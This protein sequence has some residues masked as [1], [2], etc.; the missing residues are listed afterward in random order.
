VEQVL[1]SKGSAEGP[2]LEAASGLIGAD[3]RLLFELVLG[4][5]RWLRRLDWVLGKAAGRPFEKIEAPIRAPLRI[6]AYQLLFLDRVPSYA[7]VNE[8]V[9]DVRRRER[10][11][12]TG[13]ANAVLRRIGERRSL[14]QW[15]VE[16]RSPVERLGVE[17]SHPDFLIERWLDR[18][19]E[20]AVVDLLAA[21][22]RPKPMHLLCFG[23]RQA[24]AAEL[25][26]LGVETDGAALSP[27]GLRV[28]SGDP[29]ATHLFRQGRVY[30]QDDASQAA[31]LVPPPAPGEAILDA[32]ASPGGKG[33]SL[34]AAESTVT[35]VAADV[36]MR[37]LQKLREN[38]KRL[39]LGS[40]L[41][42]ASARFPP[43]VAAFDR[44]ILD[45]PCSGTGT[46]ARHPELKWR[47]SEK[48]ILRLATEG[49]AMLA[50]CADAVRPGGMLCVVTCSL[51]VEENEHV[52]RQFLEQR[53]DFEALSLDGRLPVSMAAGVEADGRWR[54][55]TTQ[56]HD[57]FT[58]HVMRRR[59]PRL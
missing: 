35:L 48:E 33:F 7:V 36:S 51:E 6:A 20:S 12:A 39:R 47:L 22:N 4:S 21:N 24:I 16:A 34:K 44:V 53:D 50:S 2:L 9:S 31:A 55:L 41:L 23:D 28:I 45:L 3:R 29:L 38:E 32:A 25:G 5:L 1:S 27:L 56:D 37:R 58:V 8:A 57:G 46:L 10:H 15:P 14:S 52:V 49:A 19:E 13:F 59:N 26:D 18:F 30:V 54:V 42:A 40:R 43:L 17:T 11:R